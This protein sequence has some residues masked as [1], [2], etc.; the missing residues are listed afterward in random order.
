MIS[1]VAA[2]IARLRARLGGGA[3]SEELLPE[4]R[5]AEGEL[6]GPRGQLLRSVD[7]G[8]AAHLLGSPEAVRVWVDLL[9]L[10]ADVLRTNGD[11]EAAQLIEARVLQLEGARR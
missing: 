8:T 5:A 3:T 1:Q 11:I 9:R 2:A 4:I 6:L 10:E 7:A